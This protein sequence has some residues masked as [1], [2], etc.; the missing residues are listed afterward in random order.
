[1][2]VNRGLIVSVFTFQSR[3]HGMASVGVCVVSTAKRGYPI[4]DATHITFRKSLSQINKL[5]KKKKQTHTLLI[6]CYD[7][8]FFVRDCAQVSGEPWRKHRDCCLCSI[9]Y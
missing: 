1:M 3:E 5:N 7:T 6:M 9:R 4:E 8:Y 2:Y